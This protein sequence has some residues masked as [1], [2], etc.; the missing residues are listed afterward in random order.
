MK[1]HLSLLA[2]FAAVL[3]AFAPMTAQA[4]LD[5]AANLTKP[6]TIETTTTASGG[7]IEF[8]HVFDISGSNKCT[9]N[10]EYRIKTGSGDWGEWQTASASGTTSYKQFYQNSITLSASTTYAIQFRGI[11]STGFGKNASTDYYR[12]ILGS[13]STA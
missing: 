11:N 9:V 12:I 5:V 13:G 3:S 7:K 2:L 8:R 1:K 10:L 4:T 6:F